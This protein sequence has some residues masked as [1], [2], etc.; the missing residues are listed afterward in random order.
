MTAEGLKSHQPTSSFI[1][2]DAIRSLSEHIEEA[3]N[4]LVNVVENYKNLY[5]K[6]EVDQRKL[7]GEPYQRLIWFLFPSE[8]LPDLMSLKY[9]APLTFESLASFNLQRENN[10]KSN[11]EFVAPFQPLEYNHGEKHRFVFSEEYATDHKDGQD[12]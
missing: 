12:V 7:V 4:T 6:S 11:S 2:S 9:Q 3:R 8:V 5:G 10:L 1:K